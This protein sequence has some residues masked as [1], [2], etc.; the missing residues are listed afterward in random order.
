MPRGDQPIDH[1]FRRA[2]F[3]ASVSDLSKFQGLSLSTVIA[4]LVDY[5]RQGDDVDAARTLVHCDPDPVGLDRDLRARVGQLVQHDGEVR[6][7]GPLDE[8]VAPGHDG[9]DGPGA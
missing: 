6:R 8:H 5:A 3:G 2:V 4:F 1:L 9:A 7:H